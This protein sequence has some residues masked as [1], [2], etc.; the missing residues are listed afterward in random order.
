MTKEKWEKLTTKA[1]WDIQAAF[2]GPDLKSSNLVKWWTTSVI[3][4]QMKNVTRV[5]GLVNDNLPMVIVP[6]DWK[7]VSEQ[8]HFDSYHFLEHVMTAAQYLYIPIASL[9]GDWWRECVWMNR[10]GESAR[11]FL[12]R[13]KELEERGIYPKEWVTLLESHVKWL[14]EEGL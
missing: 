1:Q 5:G 2:R 6:Q 14:G 10:Y 4:G 13:F 11:A 7:V 12:K 3:R 8:G 9:P